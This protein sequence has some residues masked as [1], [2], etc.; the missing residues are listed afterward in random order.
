[1]LLNDQ[2]IRSALAGGLDGAVSWLLIEPLVAP[3]LER[4]TSMSEL[5]PLDVRYFHENA[6]GAQ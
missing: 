6:E 5:Y 1:M 2:R 3:R 4:A